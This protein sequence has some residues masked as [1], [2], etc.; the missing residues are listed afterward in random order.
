MTVSNHSLV[1]LAAATLALTG[2]GQSDV[3][4]GEGGEEGAGSM[5][6]QLQANCVAQV[7]NNAAMAT[8]ANQICTCATERARED[9]SVADLMAGEM[10]KLDTM[11]R[12]CA[13]ETLNFDSPIVDSTGTKAL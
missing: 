11:I 4:V 13:T 5:V 7:E 2:C 3:S 10:T 6:A 12:R 1:P 8:A 9:L